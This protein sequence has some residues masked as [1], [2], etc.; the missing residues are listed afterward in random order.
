MIHRSPSGTQALNK[1]ETVKR[2]PYYSMSASLRFGLLSLR[3]WSDMGL[4]AVAQVN[5]RPVWRPGR[6]AP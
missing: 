2:Q 1:A 6:A 5:A 4:G 3:A